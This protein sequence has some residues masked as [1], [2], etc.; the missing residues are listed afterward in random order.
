MQATKVRRIV[1]QEFATA[2]NNVDV[3]LAPTTPTTAFPI[4]EKFSPMEM[5]A[6]D[7]LTVPASL[8]GRCF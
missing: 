1:V 8:A 5:Y 3:L 6:K 4:A 7:I 2:F